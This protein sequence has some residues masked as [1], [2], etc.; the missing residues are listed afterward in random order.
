MGFQ[1]KKTS[2]CLAIKLENFTAPK[3]PKNNAARLATSIIKPFV[4]PFKIC[5]EEPTLGPLISLGSILI[6]SA[7][8]LMCNVN[9]VGEEYSK[10]SL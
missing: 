10:N 4:K 7:R 5:S 2:S 9:L 3:S 1:S 8:S 6:F